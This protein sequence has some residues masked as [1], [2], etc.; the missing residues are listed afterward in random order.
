MI[1]NK[2]SRE[3][4]SNLA[5]ELAGLRR[6]GKRDEAVRRLGSEKESHLYALAAALHRK[7][8][9]LPRL[10]EASR[11][12]DEETRSETG[13]YFPNEINIYDVLPSVEHQ[14]GIGVGVGV[15]QMFDL[16]V[17][18]KMNEVY[19][20][21]ITRRITVTSKALLEIGRMHKALRGAYPTPS[22]FLRYLEKDHVELTLEMLGDAFDEEELELVREQLNRKSGNRDDR[23]NPETPELV[24][25]WLKYKSRQTEYGSWI[26]SA[27]NLARL[28]R[29]YEDGKIH[30]VRA[31]IAGEE[32][33]ARLAE[34][35]RAQGKTVSTV[36]VS[37]ALDYLG[38]DHEV[39]RSG[40]YQH[41]VE[42][43]GKLPVDDDSILI[44]CEMRAEDDEISDPYIER[45]AMWWTYRVQRVAEVAEGP[46]PSS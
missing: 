25:H 32:G 10:D 13:F 28:F 18:S 8:E 31:D 9:D 26:S 30:V 21:D 5:G 44:S 33:F 42:N 11:T 41:F 27:K 6:D 7:R 46:R 29:A 34:R 17:N 22:E 37:N 20:T 40:D 15:D 43:L 14:D 12:I 16:F 24:H 39:L 4:R 2:P 3:Y 1:R 23:N 36:Y 45:S 19:L 38:R 35:L